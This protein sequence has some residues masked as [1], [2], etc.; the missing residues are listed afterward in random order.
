MKLKEFL[1][2]VTEEP[3]HLFGSRKCGAVRAGAVLGGGRA[4]GDLVRVWQGS[5]IQLGVHALLVQGGLEEPGVAVKLH[6]V[7]NLWK[8]IQNKSSVRRTEADQC[9]IFNFLHQKQTP[10]GSEVKQEL[11][12]LA[13][14]SSLCDMSSCT[15]WKYTNLRLGVCVQSELDP[16]WACAT[17][18]LS[19]CKRLEALL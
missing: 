5:A 4:A 17:V 8:K 13:Y 7:E 15:G 18:C 19:V 16:P 2:E 3:L 9:V 10:V 11:P 6:Q 12:G 14:A 1:L